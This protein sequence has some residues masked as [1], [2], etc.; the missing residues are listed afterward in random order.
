MARPDFDSIVSLIEDYA[1]IVLDN[2]GLVT[3]W[4]PGAERTTGYRADEIIGQHLS[5]FYTPEDKT[6]NLPATSLHAVRQDGKYEAAGWRV[7]K[8]GSRF[9]ANV[10]VAALR[11]GEGE[12]I[13]F[14]TLTKDLTEQTAAREQRALRQVAE[15][16]VRERDTFL[17]KVSHEIR[18]P[19]SALKLYIQTTQEELQSGKTERVLEKLP[20]RLQSI[21]RQIDRIDSLISGLTTSAGTAAGEFELKFE[22]VDLA[23]LAVAAIAELTNAARQSGSEIEFHNP[24]RVIGRWSRRHLKDVILNLLQ[25]AIEFGAGKPIAVAV[26][27]NDVEAWISIEDHGVGISEHDQERIFECLERTAD[28][29]NYGDFGL[30]LWISRRIMS[31]MGGDIRIQSRMGEGATFIVKLPLVPANANEPF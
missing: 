12:L 5:R 29:R 17:A 4:S 25:N 24:G 15:T 1:I 20:A 22:D 6:R 2:A 3:R 30:G 14:L 28:S 16:A 10:A 9:W 27:A 8:D 11:N 23:D 19:L 7:R 13:G 21:H 26:G 31:A 18:N